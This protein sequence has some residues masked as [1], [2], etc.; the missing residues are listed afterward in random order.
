MTSNPRVGLLRVLLDFKVGSELLFK[1][2][3]GEA[4]VIVIGI[5]YGEKGVIHVQMRNKQTGK[6]FQ[7]DGYELS[8]EF[9]IIK[10]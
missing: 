2:N 6:I 8:K 7:R 10:K 5:F 3:Q 1:N 9:S 4:I